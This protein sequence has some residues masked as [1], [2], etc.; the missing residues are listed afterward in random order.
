[1]TGVI[2]EGIRRVDE[3]RRIREV[4]PTP[5]PPSSLPK[6]IPA[7]VTDRVER[8]AAGAGP[9]GQHPG[10][11]SP[12][13]L[14]RSEFETAAAGLRPPPA[15]PARR[16]PRRGH[17]PRG[18]R[19]GVIQELLGIATER[20][21]QKRYDKALEAYEKVLAVDRL[22][23]N[24]KKGLIAVVEARDARARDAQ[25]AARQGARS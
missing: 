18:R 19:A 7:E 2:M 5:A 14:R 22:N 24:A 8:Q 23:Q 1:M 12:S 13:R 11:A 6:D 17:A 9:T 15:R 4:F 16:G 25:R 10:R 20:L 3:W 21:A